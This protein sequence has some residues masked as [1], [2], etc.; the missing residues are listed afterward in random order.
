MNKY[1][2]LIQRSFMASVAYRAE[3]ILWLLLD[4]FPL[5]ILFFIWL[6]IFQSQT[7]VANFSLGTIT[8]YYLLVTLIDA[9]SSTHFENWRVEEIRAGK[10]DFYL[11]RPLSYLKELLLRDLGGKLFYISFSLPFFGLV[12]LLISQLAH[13]TFSQITWLQLVIFVLLIIINYLI[14][15][16]IASMIVMV[17]FWFEYAEGLEHFKW[18]LV[19]L[20]S[21]WMIPVVMMPSWL[22]AVVN[23]LPFK[24][25]FA[26][27]V[28]VIQEN[29]WLTGGDWLYLGLFGLGLAL[30]THLVWNK[31]KLAYSSH[32]G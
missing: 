5:F 25:L 2:Q 13:L 11:I 4:T 7:E 14:Q 24:Y 8:E 19:T 29:Y 23:A 6:S 26:V 27:P 12:F 30:A 10:I 22:Q 32:G 21:G 15:F 1:W 18:L 16:F 9:L 17:G 28:A 20:L 3:V 31:A